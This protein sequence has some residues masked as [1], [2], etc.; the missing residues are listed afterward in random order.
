MPELRVRLAERG[1]LAFVSQDHYIPSQVV[2]P[3]IEAREA[4]LAFC[5]TALSQDGHPW[6]DGSSQ[7][8][9][10]E[11]WAWHRHM[12]FQDCGL[13]AGINEGGVSELFF[14]IAVPPLKDN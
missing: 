4:L 6:L 11:P 9:E 8:G 2:T 14:R 1:D 5:L 3:R 10:P 13:I 12:G 7:A